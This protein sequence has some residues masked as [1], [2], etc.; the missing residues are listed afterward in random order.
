MLT[1]DSATNG[2]GPQIVFSESGSGSQM[3]GAYIG[4]AREGSN[5]MGT[6]VFGTRGTAGDANTVPTERLKI[7]STGS[8]QFS[9]GLFDEKCK[10]VSGQLSDNDN[11]NLD[12][13]M[14]YYFSVAEDTTA[15]PNIRINASNTLQDAMDIGDVCTVTVIINA[16]AAGYYANVRIDGNNV[17]EE[18]VGGAAP[19]AGSADGLDIYCYTIIKIA[20]ATGDSGFK[21][22]AN[23]TNATN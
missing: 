11:I 3:A 7:T 19:S 16:A 10:I 13:G 21:V 4:H 14:V 6:L 12:Q 9:N 2:E 18:W 1:G 5:S 8:F 17:T 20:D 22:I 23:M 15:S